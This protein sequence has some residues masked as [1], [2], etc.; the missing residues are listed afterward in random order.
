M[1]HRTE[2]KNAKALA[3]PIVALT[4]YF[5]L[6]AVKMSHYWREGRLWAEE[7][8]YFFPAI[9]AS[10]TLRGLFFNFNGHLEL[11]TNVVVWLATLVD[12]EHAPLVTTYLSLALQALPIAYVAMHHRA[13]NLAPSALPLLMV[14]AAGIPQATEVWANS[15]NLHF[16]FTILAALIAATPNGTGWPGWIKNAMLML[17]GLSGIPPLFLTPVF[18]MLAVSSKERERWVQFGILAGC[19]LVQA[20]LL[21][22][23]HLEMGQ[24]Q[25][26]L[27]PA[28]LWLSTLTQCFVAPM[29]GK[30][31]SD[32]VSTIMLQALK[33]KTEGVLT[34]ALL[35]FPFC[36]LL[37]K[38]HRSE[39]KS[40]RVL[41]ACTL[42]VLLLSM[43]TSLGDKNE[44]LWYGRGGRYFY[45]PNILLAVLLL[46]LTHRFSSFGKAACAA[47]LITSSSHIKQIALGPDWSTNFGAATKQGPGVYQIWPQGWVMT[48]PSMHH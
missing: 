37:L 4:L 38:G 43:A 32:H 28:I 3:W 20:S 15:I 6:S 31:P 1:D 42:T 46:S 12:L 47:V 24:R 34:I 8:T 13:L 21:L 44:L 23:N 36:A 33:L 25:V 48:V 11:S 30:S 26:A 16:H 39:Y 7:G 45:A 18:L 29:L 40:D 35:S 22:H 17:S 27:N 10:E 2:Q 19:G 41:V 5:A 9:A 14:V